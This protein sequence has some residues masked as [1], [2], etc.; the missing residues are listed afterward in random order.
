VSG[1]GLD[2]PLGNKP[3]LQNEDRPGQDEIIH[4]FL[5]SDSGKARLKVC[6]F[7]SGNL[8]T[9]YSHA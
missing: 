8:D 3:V 2:S 9:V 7:A 1:H 4:W 6:F 5:K